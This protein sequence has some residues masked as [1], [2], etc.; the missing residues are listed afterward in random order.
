M[1]VFDAV[2]PKVLG[3]YLTV[4]DSIDT[5][6]NIPTIGSRVHYISNFYSFSISYLFH[7]NT[8]NI[9]YITLFMICRI[10]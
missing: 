1:T 5:E 9:P 7:Q 2:V 10:L 4:F 3:T 8:S 6:E